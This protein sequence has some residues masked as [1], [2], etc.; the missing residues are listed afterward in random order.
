MLTEKEIAV[1]EL[2]KKGLKQT[3]VAEKLKITQA[4]VSRFE[5][6]AMAKL[7]DAQKLIEL[8]K[9]LRIG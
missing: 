4:A 2:R 3:E 9:K 7:A 8:A 5:K 1:M 6:N